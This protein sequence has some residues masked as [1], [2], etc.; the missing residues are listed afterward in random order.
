M[1]DGRHRLAM[2]HVSAADSI[3][4]FVLRERM[5]HE[6]ALVETSDKNKIVGWQDDN[7]PMGI[8][9]RVRVTTWREPIATSSSSKADAAGKPSEPAVVVPSLS[10][11]RQW[12]AVGNYYFLRDGPCFMCPMPADTK[13]LDRR[14]LELLTVP[15]S[16]ALTWRT[17][18]RDEA[19]GEHLCRSA[20]GEWM[21]RVYAGGVLQSSRAIPSASPLV[22]QSLQ[23]VERGVASVRQLYLEQRRQADAALRELEQCI[24]ASPLLPVFPADSIDLA[25]AAGP[26]AVQPTVK[27]AVLR[28][29]SQRLYEGAL[30]S[31]DLA[32]RA[33]GFGRTWL[34]EA[35]VHASALSGVDRA[36]AL[37]RSP[38]SFPPPGGVCEYEGAYQLGRAHGFGRR[39]Q[40]GSAKL[41]KELCWMEWMGQSARGNLRGV[42]C[43]WLYRNQPNSDGGAAIGARLPPSL[44][45]T[46]PPPNA[47]TL[48]FTFADQRER[49]RL[50]PRVTE[51]L[52]QL[53]AV[54]VDAPRVAEL[55]PSARLRISF[56]GAAAYG[57]VSAP[58]SHG[59]ADA[60][61]VHSLREALLP[62]DA[63]MH[64]DEQKAAEPPTS[65]TAPFGSAGLRH[66]SS[67]A[68]ES[69]SPSVPSLLCCL[70][71]S[72]QLPASVQSVQSAA[73]VCA[74]LSAAHP[75]A[76]AVAAQLCSAWYRSLD[77]PQLKPDF[78]RR[79]LRETTAG[80][81]STR[82][83]S[84]AHDHS[85]LCYDG[86][87]IV[88]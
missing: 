34:V 16:G 75:G 39:L 68:V 30:H 31:G 23:T 17:F 8:K 51:A 83:W 6:M 84:R 72:V 20:E 27:I 5:G 18:V 48:D 45:A 87:A 70:D 10:P 19:E 25:E 32:R 78:L 80:D 40:R 37:L 15:Q 63:A 42:Q 52:Q 28:P 82:C 67:A 66:S 53:S 56:S 9:P 65:R 46:T 50:E 60:S 58:V 36:L 54:T 59:P 12:L 85:I 26:A 21:T 49:K 79:T 71:S 2:H 76:S 74:R 86:C 62:G 47:T 57:A 11:D 29:C 69:A 13:Q 35:N 44:R 73:A 38:P 14:V 22:A 3:D 4:G 1:S 61:S 7:D 41:P 64:S 77:W 55:S 81:T 33:H 88:R 43:R 24:A